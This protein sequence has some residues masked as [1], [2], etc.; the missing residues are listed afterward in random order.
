MELKTCDYCG[1]EYQAELAQCPLCGKSAHHSEEVQPEA[2]PRGKGGSRAAGTRAASRG[3]KS[4]GK[5]VAEKSDRIPGWMWTVT[6]IILGIA[7]LLGIF[8]FIYVMG[9]FSKD[10]GDE[11][12]KVPETQQEQTVPTV[13]DQTEP[14]QEQQ[15]EVVAD[16]NVKPCTALTLSQN[17]ITLDEKGGYF[18]LTVLA[19]PADCTDPIEYHC[20][21]PEVVQVDGSGSSCM[22][23]ALSTGAAVVEVT[24]GSITK[25]CTIICEFPMDE[26]EQKPEE[27]D[28]SQQPD[29][30]AEPEPEKQPSLSS[31]DF[32]LFHPGEET[33]LK[34]LD[35][36]AG[37]AITFSSSNPAVATVT[38]GGTVKAV[39]SGT[40]NITVMVND[41]KLT[42]VARCN[43]ADSAETG[44]GGETAAPSVDY[45]ISHSDVT[46]FTLGESFQI[47]LYDET[48]A[49]V[50]GE[51]WSS[52][53][54]GACTVSAN[55]TVSAVGTGT[56]TVSTTYGGKT[57][58]CIVR[59]SIG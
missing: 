20:V 52:S 6:C 39:G 30:P 17:S 53:N 41:V 19:E 2:A 45:A 15:E 14:E 26:E 9:F 55:G 54:A 42:C 56:A 43:L 44:N 50:T 22:I 33:T 4:K 31:T 18:F 5:R 8:Y 58:S 7:V 38:A 57:Y 46:L 12:F 36:P 47:T 25:S 29:T 35:A 59:C 23:T 49:A 48:G 3:G 24:C 37:A 51:S 16:P 28:P 40:A 34:V 32:T 27:T 10:K 1:T 13:S 11:N 21:D